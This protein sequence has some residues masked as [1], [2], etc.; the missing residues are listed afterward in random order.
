MKPHKIKIDVT[1]VDKN[2]IY[3][4]KTAK[5]LNCAVWPNKDGADQYGNTHY[6]VQEVSKEA[7]ARGEKGK[8]IGN[9]RL[10][11]ED[12]TIRR[13]ARPATPTPAPAPAPAPAPEPEH[14][15]DDIPF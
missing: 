8:I 9:L 13:Q 12:E 15:P 14:E 6:I 10:E 5:Y 1:K 3:Q 7:R 2:H 11:R 4:G